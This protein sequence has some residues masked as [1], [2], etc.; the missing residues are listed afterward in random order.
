MNQLN[1]GYAINGGFAEYA[2]ATP[3]TSCA[4]PTASTRRT[5]RR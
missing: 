1:M 3:A 2:S 4:S 5:P